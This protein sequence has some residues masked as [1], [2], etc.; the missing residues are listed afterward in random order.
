MGKGVSLI[1]SAVEVAKEVKTILETSGLNR[2][3]ESEPPREFYVTDSPV[4]FIKV[5]ERFLEN[6]IEHIELITEL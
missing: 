1:D 2:K 5:G 6:R 4:R 3:Q